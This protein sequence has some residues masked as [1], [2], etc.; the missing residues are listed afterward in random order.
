[1]SS[2]IASA[3]EG[4]KL[5]KGN[6]LLGVVPVCA[7]KYGDFVSLESVAKLIECSVSIKGDS[8]FLSKDGKI[9]EFVSDAAVARLNGQIQPLRHPP[10]VRDGTWWGEAQGTLVLLNRFLG[11]SG[12]ATGLRWAGTGTVEEEKSL[13]PSPVVQPEASSEGAP[14]RVLEE[15]RKELGM[16]APSPSDSPAAGVSSPPGGDVE[17]IRWWREGD[18][19]R[20][21]FDLASDIAPLVSRKG[22][23]VEVRF[24]GI[25]AGKIQGGTSPY[26]EELSLALSRSGKDLLCV[27][28]RPSGAG[29]FAEVKSFSLSNPPRFVL[30]FGMGGAGATRP[31]ALATPVPPVPSETESQVRSPLPLADPASPEPPRRTT[32][33]RPLVVIDAGHGGKDP[34]AV[35]NALREKDINLKVAL[36]LGRK[37]RDKGYDVRFTR[38]TDVYLKLQERTDIANNA[39]ADLFVSLHVN[40]LPPGRHATGMEIYIMALP[41]DEDAMKLALFENRELG[42]EG[43]QSKEAVD[44]KT[45]ML[46][47]I[48]G[49]MQQNAKIS[50]S[51]SFAEVLFRH[52]EKWGLPMRRVAQAPFFVLRG[53]GMPSVLVEMGFLTERSEA[54]RL[55]TDAYQEKIADSLVSGI[56]AYIPPK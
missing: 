25:V 19:V 38:E 15:W 52:G 30:D 33:S 14:S 20:V 27:F 41:T 45:Q 29:T 16:K 9:L 23:T 18:S 36:K 56:V 8:L 42:G 12:G 44:K 6:V 34:G 11:L 32:R 35:A 24:P 4:R 22:D 5:W 43:M 40:A 49:D 26:G 10:L 48:L 2:D 1:M 7:E 53:A 50:E 46:L 21:V 55:A 54:K 17:R 28:S 39:D 31:P 47:H 13:A 37:L 3:Q 51:M